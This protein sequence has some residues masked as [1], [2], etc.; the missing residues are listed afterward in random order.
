MIEVF[1]SIMITLLLLLIRF[2]N[3]NLAHIQFLLEIDIEKWNKE[4]TAI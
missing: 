2:R 4:C 1:L 3:G